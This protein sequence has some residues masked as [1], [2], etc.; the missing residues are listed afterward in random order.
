[1]RSS[2]PP[3]EM[4]AMSSSPSENV[5]VS[6]TMPRIGMGGERA[7]VISWQRAPG[8]RVAEREPVCVVEAAGV[9]AAVESSATGTLV[10]IVARA[11]DVVASGATLAEIATRDRRD[12]E[13]EA[14]ERAAQPG[15]ALEPREIDLA[16]FRSP[17]VQRLIRE[18]QLD[19]FTV[20]GTGRGGRVTK[21]DVLAYLG[22]DR[23][24]PS[25]H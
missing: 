9:R 5:H 21:R 1:M 25:S 16:A 10:R 19:P 12:R 4:P 8:Q 14:A 13:P 15:G 11:G 24:P 6:M 18:H 2:S 23:S 3:F 22:E 7:T 17:A 20:G